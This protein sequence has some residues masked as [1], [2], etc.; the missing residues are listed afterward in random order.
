MVR[1]VWEVVEKSAQT[2]G[3][4]RESFQ[5]GGVTAEKARKTKSENN[6]GKSEDLTQMQ[7]E[8]N[9]SIR[10]ILKEVIL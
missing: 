2:D 7:L 3:N 1:I 6:V 8:K 5:N 10:M 4:Q 9:N